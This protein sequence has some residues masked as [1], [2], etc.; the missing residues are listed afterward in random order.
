M[1]LLELNIKGFGLLKNQTIRFTDGINIIYGR[2][3]AGKS[4]I[5]TFIKAM[6][7]GMERSRGIASLTDTWARYEP[8]NDKGCYEGIMKIWY[9]GHI[10]VIERSFT[11]DAIVPLKITNETTGMLVSPESDFIDKVMCGLTESGFTNT[12]SIGQLQSAG[13]EG[14]Y[15]ELKRYIANINSTANMQIDVAKTYQFLQDQKRSFMDQIVPEAAKAY[16]SNLSEIR[17]IESEISS[18]EYGDRFTSIKEQTATTSKKA[19]MLQAEKEVMIERISGQKQLLSANG[20][21]SK[22]DIEEYRELLEEARKEYESS[23]AKGNMKPFRYLA[24]L[25]NIFGV[26]FAGVGLYMLIMGNPNLL[27]TALSVDNKIA[28]TVAIIIGII[29]FSL[30]IWLTSQYSGTIHAQNLAYEQL[31]DM[32]LEKIADGEISREND[33][34]MDQKL[35]EMLKMYDELNENEQRLIEITEDIKKLHLVRDDITKSLEEHQISQWE[36]EKQLEHLGNLKDEAAALKRVIAENERLQFEIDA[37][38]IAQDV[39]SSLST[40]IRDSFGTYLNKEASVL[41]SGITGGVYDSMFIDDE[42]NIFMNTRHRLIPL[43]QIS[44]GTMDQI[45]L[46]LRLAVASFLASGGEDLPLLFDDSFANYDEKR[47]RSVFRWMQKTF[48]NRQ[49]LIFS[50]HKREAQMLT[51][52]Q[53]NFNLIDLKHMK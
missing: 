6:L 29:S 34:K 42:L 40:S 5:H 51:S 32:Y 21:R 50:C 49:M 2:N 8:W 47:L 38:T 7:Y 43:E 17:G 12:I 27:S 4:T 46:A 30:A 45:Y 39:I 52:Q 15:K 13:D 53:I 20:F 16:T 24:W 31:S 1:K 14:M 3:E 19:E 22:E 44:R 10:Y 35:E 36:L 48:R 11:K 26:F 23:L 28:T 18:P 25:F 41:V 37:I 9:E 33:E